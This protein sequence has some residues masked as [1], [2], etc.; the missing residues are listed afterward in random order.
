MPSALLPS[1]SASLCRPSHRRFLRWIAL[2]TSC[3][4][5]SY[6]RRS[7]S[8]LHAPTLRGFSVHS[9]HSSG[10]QSSV[11]GVLASPSTVDRNPRAHSCPRPGV[12]T[13][14]SRQLYFSIGM[15]APLVQW[16]RPVSG[17]SH[18]STATVG[19]LP[20]SDYAFIAPRRVVLRV[21][22]SAFRS[23]PSTVLSAASSSARVRASGCRTDPQRGVHA[24]RIGG[25]A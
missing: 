5:A 20:T 12:V 10:Y 22:L 6:P 1:A 11:I 17:P 7:A 19:S 8:L 18:A 2:P 9:A 3:S 25:R 24:L 4:A 14:D 15:P 13:D 16:S 23:P 21:A